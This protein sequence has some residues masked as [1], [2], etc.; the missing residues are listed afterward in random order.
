[1]NDNGD[2]D[3]GHDRNKPVFRHHVENRFHPIPCGLLQTFTEELH[4]IQEQAQTS[5]YLKENDDCFHTGS[6]LTILTHEVK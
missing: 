6:T 5:N 4:S 1:L 2:N 3:T